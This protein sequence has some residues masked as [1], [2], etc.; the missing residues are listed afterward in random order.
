MKS[1]CERKPPPYLFRYLPAP[2]ADH[3]VCSADLSLRGGHPSGHQEE[4]T[5]IT[6]VAAEKA[7]L[8]ARNRP[9][10]LIDAVTRLVAVPA[11]GA[12]TGTDVFSHEVF[13]QN[14]VAPSVTCSAKATNSFNYVPASQ[15]CPPASSSQ[16]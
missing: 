14:L 9:V 1:R 5:A 12:V 13:R 8:A 16:Y 7:W 2:T 11:A 4:A 10:T 15:F 6:A 3:P